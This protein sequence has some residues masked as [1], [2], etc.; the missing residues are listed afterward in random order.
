MD[1]GEVGRELR[2]LEG[3]FQ[4]VFVWNGDLPPGSW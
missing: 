3:A 4:D 1:A 2:L